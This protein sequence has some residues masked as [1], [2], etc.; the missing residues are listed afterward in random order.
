MFCL[1]LAS[2]RKS[3]N[4]TVIPSSALKKAIKNEVDKERNKNYRKKGSRRRRKRLCEI[5][6]DLDR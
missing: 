2:G 3:S 6:I 4:L 1:N 5:N